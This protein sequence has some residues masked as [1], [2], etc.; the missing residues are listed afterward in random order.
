MQN[1][2]IQGAHKATNFPMVL[3]NVA[4]SFLWTFLCRILE[5]NSD[6]GMELD[7]QTLAIVRLAVGKYEGELVLH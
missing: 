7:N 4:L 1:L 5:I 2:A 6:G 3:S